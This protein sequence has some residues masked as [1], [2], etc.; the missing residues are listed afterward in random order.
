[1]WEYNGRQF[2]QEE[3]EKAAQIANLSFD[4]YVQKRGITK[5]LTEEKKE[6]MPDGKLD[7][8]G[9]N[10]VDP[11]LGFYA[12][13]AANLGYELSPTTGR[14]IYS[15]PEK[16]KRYDQQLNIEAKKKCEL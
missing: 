16:Q 5:V 11:E 12:K 2:T 14:R 13:G 6:P 3:V 10:R 7:L 4:E 15:D 9:I 1:M 8:S